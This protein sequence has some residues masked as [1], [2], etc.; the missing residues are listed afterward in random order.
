M[1]SP[2]SIKLIRSIAVLLLP[3]IA[4]AQE[5][6]VALNWKSDVTVNTFLLGQMHRQYDQRRMKLAEAGKTRQAARAY[7]DAMRVNAHS[8]L[9][10]R[11]RANVKGEVA[12]RIEK[13]GFRIER[14]R[15]SGFAGS[16]TANL[17]IPTGEGRFP[18]VLFL[19]GHEDLAKAT[20][21]YQ[22]TA[23][24]LVAR[25]FVV[26][27]IDPVSQAERHQ[28]L[29]KAGKPL[30]RG[31][32]TEHTLINQAAA[33]FGLSTA[34]YQ[35][36]DN[37]DGISYLFSRPEVDTTRLGCVGNSGG[38]IQTIYLAAI[39]PR[40]KVISVSSYFSSR[41]RTFDLSGAADGCAH[42][43]NEGVYRMEMADFLLAAAPKPILIT[44][45]S[46]DFID[47]E[48]ARTAFGEMQTI[49]NRLNAARS[50]S[51]FTYDDGHGLSKPKRDTT[52]A[53]F[54]RWLKPGRQSVVADLPVADPTQLAVSPSGQV[55]E[56]YKEKGIGEYHNRLFEHTETLRANFRRMPVQ[57]QVDS[58][59]AFLQV[60]DNVVGEA[61]SSAGQRN[62]SGIVFRMM[63][64]RV[65]GQPPLPLAM[66]NPPQQPKA[67]LLVLHDAGMKAF[68]DST[69]KIRQ[70]MNA[71]YQVVLADVRGFGETADKPA[72][73]D[74]KYFNR[75]YRNT[76]LA[77]HNGW[78]MPAQRVQDML[79]LVTYLRAQ[80]KLPICLLSSGALTVPALHAAVLNPAIQ[81]V[82]MV[83][84]IKSYKEIL[85]RPLQK[86]WYSVVIP[87]VLNLY[88]LPDLLQITGDRV[89]WYDSIPVL[90]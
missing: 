43:P 59:R 21:S 51:M 72:L 8:L 56:S 75:E 71:G 11:P 55:L 27:V 17:Y 81:R 83:D 44:A 22:Q 4:A 28:F 42:V 64:L 84:G 73:N 20:L 24:A 70:W 12:G 65:N 67:V 52:V 13:N 29:D 1:G 85:D 9:A 60:R 23:L 74:P 77:I 40:I 38:A 15:Y 48:G 33:L 63:R 45:G 3:F 35:A 66:L 53:W 61:D 30:T 6:V 2:L 18:A 88:D 34:A 41:E 90:P 10:S 39:D 37:Q 54:T 7:V 87:G 62:R 26:F 32:T 58:I 50:L 79:H 14:I 57:Q 16:V 89:A 69:E 25:G 36:W 68:A 49:Y 76:M 78:S 19:C 86:D 47:Y 46:Y 80:T 82:F 5:P 31:G